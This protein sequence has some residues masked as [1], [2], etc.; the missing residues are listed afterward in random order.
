M[1]RSILIILWI[2]PYV[3]LSQ[4]SSLYE[5]V[6]YKQAVK[7]GTRS[8]D[9]KPG[10]NY[11]QNHAD[12]DI[13]VRLDTAEKRIYGKE[14]ITYYNQS[15]DTLKNIVIR[16]YQNRYKKGAI[17]DMIVHPGN[18]NEGME[19][20][21]M[22]MNGQGIMLNSSGIISNGTNLS[23]PLEEPLPSKG[24]LD[25]YCEW[26]YKIPVEQEFRR[27]GHYKDNAWFVGYFYPQIA[28]YDD[29][30]ISPEMKGWDFILFHKGNEEF[31]NDFNN[32]K[33][34]IEVPEGFYVWGTG[35]LSNAQDVY[36]QELR[37][38]LDLARKSDETVHIISENDL[39][40]NLLTGNV[41]KF[42]ANEVTDFGFGTAYNYLWD[43]TG[44]LIDDRRIFIDVAYHPES[45]VYPKVIDIARKTVKYTSEVFPEIPFPYN[46]TTTFNGMLSGGMEFPMIANN[47][48]VIDSTFM[49]LMTF[50]EICHN[51]LPFMMGINE[52][53][54]HFM[55]EGITQFYTIRFLWD[56]YHSDFYSDS[57]A[58]N[59]MSGIYDAYS[60]LC[61]S[62][63]DNSSLYNSYA[64][65]N[66]IN[67]FYQ[68]LVKSVVPYMLFTEMIGEDQFVLA[69]KE[70]CKRW[71]GKHP[72]PYDLFYTMNDVLK[73]NYNWFWKAWFL[74]PG[75]PDLGLELS[76]Q[77][78]I[79][80]RIGE[81]SLP[82][83][84]RL[85]ILYNDGSKKQIERPMS[86]WKK[87]NKEIKIEL[88]HLENIIE[89]SLD[90]EKI[91][92]ID[93]S[94]NSIVVTN[95]AQSET[96]IN[97]DDS[98]NLIPV[99]FNSHGSKLYGYFSEVR[100]EG[101]HP[102][103][104]ILHGSPGGDRD[105]L[106]LAQVVP[107]AGWNAMVFNFR[108][109]Y[110]SEGISSPNNSVEDVFSAI[111]FLK[112][113]ETSKKYRI[114]VDHIALAGW[115]YGGNIAL[116]AATGDSSIKYVISIAAADLSVIARLAEKSEEFK[117]MF[118]ETM[119][120]RYIN[121]PVKGPGGKETLEELLANADKYD[122]VKHAEDLS[123]KS[124][125]IIGGWKDQSSTLEEHVLP[126]IRALQEQGAEMIEKV[127]LDANHTFEG[128]REELATVLINWLRD[129][130]PKKIN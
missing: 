82:L 4:E 130:Y 81:G 124:L 98:D 7:N 88:D 128:K 42:K 60:D 55:D 30:E 110:N 17:R 70:F 3:I 96:T 36:S 80:K 62:T 129:N 83:P 121:G 125:L 118:I 44:V 93:H 1:K 85:N 71:K 35:D 100:G 29:I 41:W 120:D 18:I 14:S 46:H 109:F 5:P 33:V 20:D 37:K 57:S 47:S 127:V 73:E 56:M 84:V 69:F 107:R 40:N 22:I 10:H 97:Q 52:K 112:S 15:P 89:I 13:S 126:L 9:G 27:T 108:G 63:Q 11:W 25:L 28:V 99:S 95:H 24:K 39:N 115:S 8:R 48:D 86:I 65:T 26:S 51:Y 102:T 101:S 105:V 53:R 49:T 19:L 50:H 58:S 122:L 114:D 59:Y 23:I 6:N 79:V 91:P 31:Y 68:Y 111:N 123:G 32:Y 78:V 94:N 87:G 104:I 75:Y 12:Y 113:D 38:R 34:D 16:L 116:T 21:T 2:L 119:N 64:H 92:D 76:G 54:Y 61:V 117:S 66:E 77:N 90:T 106:G 103:I 45:M 67:V 74:D 43:G 72:T